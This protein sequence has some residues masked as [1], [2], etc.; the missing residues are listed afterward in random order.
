V[1]H[2]Q[3]LPGMGREVTAELAKVTVYLNAKSMSAIDRVSAEIGVSRTD[4][5]NRALQL[6][7]ALLD[8]PPGAAVTFDHPGGTD[9]TFVRGE[10]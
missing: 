7:A 1:V 3:A 2:L 8:T 10:T 9:L 5:I 6:Y 4:T